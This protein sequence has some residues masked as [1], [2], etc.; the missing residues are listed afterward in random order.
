MSIE[1]NLI[2]IC[3]TKLSRWI[4]FASP[5]I[6]VQWMIR[7]FRVAR[8]VEALLRLFF[9]SRTDLHFV[10]PTRNAIK[11]N[12]LFYREWQKYILHSGL[13]YFKPY[14]SLSWRSLGNI[15]GIVAEQ[16]IRDTTVS[17]SLSVT[18]NQ[19]IK[20]ERKRKRAM[21][22]KTKGKT[23]LFER[24]ADEGWIVATNTIGK[25]RSYV[26]YRSKKWTQKERSG[27]IRRTYVNISCIVY[28]N[29]FFFFLFLPEIILILD[30]ICGSKN[31][32]GSACRAETRRLATLKA[33]AL[34]NTY[35]QKYTHEQLAYP[36]RVLFL[37]FFYLFNFLLTTR[38][39]CVTLESV[40]A[41]LSLRVTRYSI[42]YFVW[43][44]L[45]TLSF[46]PLTLFLSLSLSLF[47]SLSLSL[48]LS[49]PLSS[50][51]LSIQSPCIAMY[52]VVCVY[53]LFMYNY[54][55]IFFYFLVSHR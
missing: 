17:R 37:I 7:L 25:E 51:P 53:A 28:F 23:K 38:V 54:L 36:L 46:S 18:E 11:S 34:A 26:R 42:Y 21:R 44:L 13:V 55:N 19:K 41:V 15:W 33:A 29:N 40:R 3:S 48:S 45:S 1:F 43:C 6:L 31:W 22:T 2:P 12:S 50:S 32:G 35:L 14:R 49:L 10:P 9:V 27:Q 52:N 20:K 8:R 47:L 30:K 39:T 5:T 16:R 4:A 24:G